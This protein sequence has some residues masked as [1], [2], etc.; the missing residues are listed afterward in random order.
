LLL[1]KDCA[2]QDSKLA[3]DAKPAIVSMDFTVRKED[4]RLLRCGAAIG[5]GGERCYAS[6]A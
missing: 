2:E 4:D 3:R 1:R 5:D 6:P